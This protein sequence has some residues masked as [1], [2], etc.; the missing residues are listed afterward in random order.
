MDQLSNASITLQFSSPLWKPKPRIR[1]PPACFDLYA[2][3][4]IAEIFPTQIR[5]LPSVRYS[6]SSQQTSHSLA[7]IV[8]VLKGA[9]YSV[10][11]LVS[12]KYAQEEAG[13]V[14]QTNE[15]LP[16]SVSTA[17]SFMHTHTASET[18]P[19]DTL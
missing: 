7:E 13:V 19:K 18:H 4:K 8:I 10:L 12:I 6:S 2:E 11:Y 1:C 15:P 9:G 17:I 16:E 14:V 3:E 5:R